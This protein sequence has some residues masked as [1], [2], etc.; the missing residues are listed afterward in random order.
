MLLRSLR[1]YVL[2][3]WCFVSA[4][5][6][7]FIFR[8]REG[9]QRD[10]WEWLTLELHGNVA[11]TCNQLYKMTQWVSVTSSQILL[12]QAL[13][14]SLLVPPELPPS[15]GLCV[16]TPLPPA[17]GFLL[18][19]LLLG[20]YLWSLTCYC[21]GNSLSIS[22]FWRKKLIQYVFSFCS[23]CQLTYAFYTFAC[24]FFFFL[25]I[26]LRWVWILA[27]AL[28]S[29]V[30][31]ADSL[32]VLWSLLVKLRKWSWPFYRFGLGMREVGMYNRSTRVLGT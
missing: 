16:A 13:G 20:L 24:F 15:Q 26:L 14:I 23:F 6:T 8:W 32:Y 7:V 12:A 1:C 25:P 5:C 4:Q 29:W 22:S 2:N 31:W 9:S 17:L 28:T 30:T 10:Y 27:Q 18:P 19:S 3:A 21:T 11:E